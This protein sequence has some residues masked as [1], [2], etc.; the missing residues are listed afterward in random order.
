MYLQH[1]IEMVQDVFPKKG[2]TEIIKD[3]NRSM[4]LFCQK[5]RVYETSS[6]VTTNPY[7]LGAYFLVVVSIEQDPDSTEKQYYKIEDGSITVYEDEEMTTAATTVNYTVRYAIKNAALAL[8]TDNPDFPEMFQD[9]IPA[10]VISDYAARAGNFQMAAYW[11]GIRRE[12][13]IE[14]TRYKNTRGDAA[15]WNI[16]Y[17]TNTRDEQ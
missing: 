7:D 17:G 13:E 16:Q 6:T 11:K 14:A 5:T 15:G 10:K 4:D 9:A 3:L 1:M 2:A 8:M 12:A